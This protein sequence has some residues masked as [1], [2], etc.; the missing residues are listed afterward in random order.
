[1]KPAPRLPPQPWMTAPATRAV[2]AAL[3]TE[4]AEVR[5]V[6]GCVRDAL[7]GRAV[8][9]IDLATH[10]PPE[11]VMALLERA[12]VKVVPTGLK[13]GTVTAVVEGAPFEITTLRRD[14][15]TDGRHAKVEFT[16]DWTA[17]ASRRDLTM[18]AIFMAP[19][20]QLFDPFGG[21][22]DLKRGRV[23]FV[24]DAATRMREDVLR[25]LRFF[26]FHAHYGKGAPDKEALEAAAE[27]APLLPALSGERVA[28][29]TLKLL[30]AP[31]PAAIMSLMRDLNILRHFL[32]E[33][34]ELERLG[35]LVRIEQAL[36]ALPNAILR[37]A[38][39][40][41]GSGAAS[42][43][44]RRLRFSNRE[45]DNLVGWSEGPELSPAEDEHGLRV[46]LYRLGQR[47]YR[48]R[49]LIA[50]ASSG[51]AVDSAPWRALASMAD[52]PVPVFPLKG[53]DGLSLGLEPGPRLG[54]ALAAV[55]AWWIA[56]DFRADRQACL[57][58]LRDII[59]DGHN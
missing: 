29:E 33:A 52:K 7:I 11:R 14:V 54:E 51:E 17:D 3:T 5:F 45:R 53:R 24:G 16:D 34:V 15:E 6:G 25:L 46:H 42:E 36:A 49:A 47:R 18:N 19:D 48:G 35:R 4:G 23:R 21:I 9:D 57:D 8:K 13:H 59:S 30:A 28:A 22:D 12:R 32:P 10:E 38:A 37:L 39:S 27:L 58:K 1:M 50:W 31:D 26:R 20:G 2:I 56:G 44:A 43:V 41:G 55:E 40:I